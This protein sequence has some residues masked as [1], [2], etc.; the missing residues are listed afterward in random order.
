MIILGI[1]PFKDSAAA[2]VKDGKILCAVAEERLNRIKHYEGFPWLSIDEC[3]KIASMGISEINVIAVG[4]N[5]Y[6]GWKTRISQSLKAILNHDKSFQS[7]ISRGNHYLKNCIEL[8]KLKQSL[9]KRY[10]NKLLSTKKIYVPHHLAH[11]SSTFLLSNYPYSNIMIADGIGESSTISFYSGKDTTINKIA[12]IKYP[13]SLGHLYSYFTGFL[14]F[15]MNSDEGKVMALAAYGQN[16]YADFFDKLIEFDIDKNKFELDSKLIDYHMARDKYF[17]QNITDITG[18]LP[19][20][21]DN[22]INQVHMDLACSLQ[23]ILEKTVLSLLKYYFPEKDMPLCAAGGLFLNSVMN[24]I[25][26]KKHSKKF[27]IQPAAGDEGVSVGSALYVSSIYDRKNKIIKINNVYWGNN[28]SDQLIKNSIERKGLNYKNFEDNYLS[29][30]KEIEKGKI[31]GWFK[32]KMEFGP[33]ALGNRSIF[34]SALRKETKEIVNLKVKKRENFRP[35]ACSVL[36]EEASMYFKNLQESPFMLKVFEFKEK[37]KSQF[38]SVTHI[39]NTCRIQTVTKRQRHL[40]NLLL[41]I[42]QLT[43][44]GL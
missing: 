4:W 37:Y 18:I 27:F 44:H 2:I 1:S 10:S 8:I 20:S 14:G 22:P 30:A 43:G 11:A 29:I 13:N 19:R 32:G 39:D 28:Y 41:Q 24:G 16:N 5:P 36:M 25:I 35:F 26:L 23:R 38:P 3:L 40:Y 21:C 31:V 42:K 12:D 34:A 33:R 6:M 7:K 17:N 15:R 9:S